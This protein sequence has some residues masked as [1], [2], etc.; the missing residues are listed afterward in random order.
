MRFAYTT[1]LLVLAFI[2][3]S[4]A[5]LTVAK[6]EDQLILSSK[7][8]AT[9]THP[10]RADDD[11]NVVRSLRSV[12]TAVEIDAVG[13]EERLSLSSIP[14]V[15]KLKQLMN[16][17]KSKDLINYLKYKF[18]VILG[19]K[20]ADIFNCWTEQGKDLDDLY[21][22]WLRADKK[23]DDVYRI[24]GIQAAHPYNSP[25]LNKFVTYRNLYNKKHGIPYS[26]A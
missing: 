2:A 9:R 20:E 17:G 3:S 4:N 1:L 6:D 8:G 21:K 22:I 10:I 18:S 23:P 19:K 24:M 14:G 11:K 5:V 13:D 7:M 12:A 16:S 15:S 26:R 25:H